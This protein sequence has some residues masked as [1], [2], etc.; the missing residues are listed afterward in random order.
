MNIRELKE[1]L[2]LMAENNLA[3]MEIEKEGMRI[4]FTKTRE[5]RIAMEQYPPHPGLPFGPVPL[6]SRTDTASPGSTEAAAAESASTVIVKSPMV[7]TFY[8]T[9]APDQPPYVAVGKAVKEGDVLC[10]VEAMKLMNEIK[11]EVS[12]TVTEILIKNGQPVEFDQP[13][14]KISK[15]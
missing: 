9:P 13:I 3:E 10:I 15:T 12:G 11:C 5:D 4:K 14:F 7:G 8:A 6:P 1:M 2:Q